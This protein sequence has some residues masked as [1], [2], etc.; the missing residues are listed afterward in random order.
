MVLDR[1]RDGV[2][3]IEWA[4]LRLAG[5]RRGAPA[6]PRLPHALVL[7]LAHAA[8]AASAPDL[9]L[10]A[11]DTPC[12][13]DGLA[14]MLGT[15]PDAVVGALRAL[16][17]AGVVRGVAGAG[18]RLPTAAAL[19]PALLGPAPRCA[20]LDWGRVALATVGAPSAWVAAH[21]L[22]ER[23]AP[24]EWTPMP[25][26]ALERALGCGVSGVRSALERLTTAGV[27][28]RREQRGGVSAY[29]FAPS[30]V[31]ARVDA[32]GGAGERWTDEAPAPRSTLR[33]P[34]PVGQAAAAVATPPPSTPTASAPSVVGA[35]TGVRLSVGGVELEV[36]PGLRVRVEV[37]PDGTPQ[38][39]LV[40]VA[41]AG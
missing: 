1:L 27:V 13:V 40:P 14:S 10:D 16:E 11:V 9:P 15:D 41:S 31:E 29:R 26:S 19:A 20:A 34:S 28:E 36:P 22:A 17:Q 18:G 5:E 35:N 38:I 21:V 8:R 30:L 12:D 39:S 6:S 3:W 32:W 37:G 4:P 24:H 25:R 2:D 23:L 7:H 33:A